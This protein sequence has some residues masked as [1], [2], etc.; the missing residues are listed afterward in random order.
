MLR[1]IPV[2]L[3]G[4]AAVL[5]QSNAQQTTDLH[6]LHVRKNIYMLV[7]AGGNITLSAGPDGVLMVDSGAAQMSDKIIAAI[8][9]LGTQLSV[10]GAPPKPIQYILNTSARPEHVGGNEKIAKSGKTFTGGNVAGDLRGL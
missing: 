4:T 5:Q 2:L 3:L 8:H 9:Q 7:G 10:D 1:L 6:I